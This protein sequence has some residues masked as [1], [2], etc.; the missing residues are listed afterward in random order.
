M[1]KSST[2]ITSEIRKE[3][4]SRG[5]SK[6]TLII[7]ALRERAFK[8]LKEGATNEECERAWFSFLVDSAVNPENKDSAL[9]MRLI[10]ERGWAAL[11]PVSD[12]VEFEFDREADFS[13]SIADIKGCG[14]WSFSCGAWHTVSWSY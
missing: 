14:G 6:K 10:T 5:K 2:T 13:S 4:P 1:A 8:G 12:Q 7:D 3:L 11:K 9:C